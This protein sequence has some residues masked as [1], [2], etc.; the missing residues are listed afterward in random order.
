[1]L[2]VIYGPCHIT[3][4]G[5]TSAEDCDFAFEWTGGSPDVSGRV[6]IG[7]RSSERPNNTWLYAER[8]HDESGRARDDRCGVKGWE[9]RGS[10]PLRIF[11]PI[12]EGFQQDASLWILMTK[13]F[14]WHDRQR[15]EITPSEAY[16]SV[17]SRGTDP[18]RHSPS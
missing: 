12:H 18:P 6:R 9:E 2:T 11:I 13:L 17:A 7:W 5:V 1:V 15:I 10:G 14:V 4:P 3:V 8:A 16:L